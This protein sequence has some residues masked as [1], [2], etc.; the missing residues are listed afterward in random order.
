MISDRLDFF[1]KTGTELF[2]PAARF[3]MKVGITANQMTA[4]SF[5]MGFL[6][7][8]F[9]FVRNDLFIIFVLLHFLCDI[10]DGE[11]AR[12]TKK[13]TRFGVWFDHL[14]DRSIVLLL[15]I[16]SYFYLSIPAMLY[17]SVISFFIVQHLIHILSK[18][19]ILLIYSRSAALIIFM[20]G[21]YMEA[22]VALLTIN[23]F[24]FILQIVNLIMLKSKGKKRRK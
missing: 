22:F 19:K 2:G 8:Y 9:L 4:I 15:L 13:T 12:T 3:F 20:F 24:G 5:F 7:V 16:K 10:L 21:F 17:W 11:I 14:A 6:A 23:M 1:R 18:R